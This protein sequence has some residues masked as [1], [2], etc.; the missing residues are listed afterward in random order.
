[1][2]RSQIILSRQRSRIKVCV[3]GGGGTAP[4]L[5]TTRMIHRPKHFRAAPLG[6]G[7]SSHFGKVMMDTGHV[8]IQRRHTTDLSHFRQT[9]PGL[10]RRRDHCRSLGSLRSLFPRLLATQP[11]SLQRR[12][13]P[14]D[15]DQESFEIFS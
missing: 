12:E 9:A 13:H 5:P 1:M 4:P 11:S 10:G 7:L 2:P 15:S 8:A 6:V 3:W 14:R